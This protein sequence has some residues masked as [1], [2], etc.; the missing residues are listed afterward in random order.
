MNPFHLISAIL[1]FLA[2]GSLLAAEIDNAYELPLQQ[3]RFLNAVLMIDKGYDEAYF[4]LRDSRARFFSSLETLSKMSRSASCPSSSSATALQTQLSSIADDWKALDGAAENLL[5]LQT[6]WREIHDAVK[7][8]N[9]GEGDFVER[10][11]K[12]EA[13]KVVN[14]RAAREISAVGHL[15]AAHARLITNANRLLN[16]SRP[17]PEV[18]FMF[19][20]DSNT[21]TDLIDGLLNGSTILRLSGAKEKMEK[22][23]LLA[24]QKQFETDKK[25]AA[26]I[27]KN[28]KSIVMIKRTVDY[29]RADNNTQYDKLRQVQDSALSL[30]KCAASQ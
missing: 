22:E 15:K 11:G 9:D 26:L 16:D 27:M 29:V 28:L 3:Q 17:N 8:I 30:S 13:I 5:E 7:V 4:Q 20:K 18:A 19:G 12:V 24:L 25:S 10:A 21:I 14:G 23:E 1:A 6:T 2:S